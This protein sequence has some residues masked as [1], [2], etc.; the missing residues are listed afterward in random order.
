MCGM[1]HFW[2]CIPSSQEHSLAAALHLGPGGSA[3][4]YRRHNSCGFD[5]WFGKTP[6]RRKWQ[7]TPVFL[8]KKSHGWRSLTDYSPWD[9]KE[10]D[11]TEWLSTQHMKGLCVGH[12]AASLCPS[13][14]KLVPDHLTNQNCFPIVQEHLTNQNCFPR[15]WK[16]SRKRNILSNR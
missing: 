14:C 16:W 2:E 9:H 13:P 15:N 8:P 10:L 3:C 12:P 4:R 1:G 6:W 11:T 7:P 5:P